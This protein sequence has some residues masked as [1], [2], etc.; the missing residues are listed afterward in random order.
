MGKQL[1]ADDARQSLNA[2]VESKGAEIFAKFGPRIGFNELEAVLGDR[3]CVRYPCAL[4]FD[5]SGL[6]PGEFAHAEAKG[7]LPE[8]GYALHIHPIFSTRPAMV[9]YLALYHL[10]TV[11][12]GEFASSDDAETFASAALGLDRELYYQAL[13]A[14]AD[15]IAVEAGAPEGHDP[16]SPGSC[17]C[18]G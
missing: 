16:G 10:V 1:T 13:C 2:H 18:G 15:E 9:P 7:E 14:L 17:T 12:Y 6:Q 3:S 5:A 4:D 11:N 8:H